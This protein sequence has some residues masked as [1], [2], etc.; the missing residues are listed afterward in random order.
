MRVE[1]VHGVIQVF[2]EDVYLDRQLFRYLSG[3]HWNKELECYEFPATYESAMQIVDALPSV[4]ASSVFFDLLEPPVVEGREV[5][6][7]PIDLPSAHPAWEH[8]RRGYAVLVNSHRN[9]IAWDMGTGKTKLII[10]TVVELKRRGEIDY[11][12]VLCKKSL[13][14]T[15]YDEVQKHQPN[16]TVIIAHAP[17]SL[18]RRVLIVQNSH[19]DEIGKRRLECDF[20]I[21][22]YDGMKV[23]EH[24]IDQYITPNTWVVMDEA[25]Q[26]KHMSQRTKTIYQILE[27]QR[28]KRRTALSGTPITN[29]PLDLFCQY[30]VL[31]HT[32]FG[33]PRMQK[34]FR[35]TYSTSMSL[36]GFTKVVGYKRLDILMRK[37]RP[38]MYRVTKEQ[39]LDIPPK[40]FSS[41]RLEM[42]PKLAKAYEAFV[43]NHVVPLKDMELTITSAL[44]VIGKALQL[45]SGFM[46]D[47]NH[48]AQTVLPVEE[49]DKL[50]MLGEMLDDGLRVQ[51]NEQGVEI[52]HYIPTIVWTYF[53]ADTDRLRKFL[54]SQHIPF[55]V[56]EGDIDE[57]RAAQ[58]QFTDGAV[59][60]I[61]VPIARG[62]MGLNL[63]R[64]T[65]VFYYCQVHSV[66]Q[67]L[68]SEDRCHRAGQTS[69]VIYYDPVY[70]GTVDVSVLRQRQSK[71][72]LAKKLLTFN[73]IVAA[74]S[75]EE[76]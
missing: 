72:D 9:Y 56:Y 19:V 43:E 23:L 49:D 26:L 45:T 70:I 15:W 34:A 20:L 17:K 10:D 53:N 46:Y 33:P 36:G 57:E 47:N 22:N 7:E 66:E 8:Q 48:V 21:L 2:P 29:S 11:C 39:C 41:V 61:V 55:C 50:K 67:R 37:V 40:L 62:A 18:D 12:L 30:L 75:G 63:Q 73:D 74:I 24:F 3:K 35:A 54:T 16:A 6:T 38:S 14:Y 76:V 60:V 27:G 52:K 4:E 58:Q 65:R 5:S 44:T 13:M 28:V 71:I 42:P 1:I 68:Q 51:T 59:D 31:D 25:T 64:A 32:V 69:T